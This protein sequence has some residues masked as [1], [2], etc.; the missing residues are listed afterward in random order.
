MIEPLRTLETATVLL[1]LAALGGLLMAGIRLAGDRNPPAWLAMAHGFLA[2]APVVLLIYAACTIGLPTMAAYGTLLLV[3]AALGGVFMNL[4]WHWK[5]Q[6]LPKGVMVAHAILAVI[7]FLMVL[8]ST[9]GAR[10]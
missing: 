10:G 6:P 9:F 4:A 7:G 8:M 1:V 2:A 3:L 5:S